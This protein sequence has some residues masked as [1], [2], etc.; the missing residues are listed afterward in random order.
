MN[1]PTQSATGN[2]YAAS[3]VQNLAA[4]DEEF[5]EVKILAVSGRIGR[6]RYLMYSVGLSILI[7]FVTGMMGALL[8]L[9]A[10]AFLGYAVLLV[11]SFML[12]IQRCHDFDASGWWSLAIFIP[13]ASFAFLLIPGTD[14]ENR[15][16]NKTPPN[17]T[18]LVVLTWLL[19]L[20]IPIGGILAAIAIP[21][22]QKYVERA[23]AEQTR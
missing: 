10:L 13:L 17:S 4:D 21:Q 2:P 22:Y 12:T 1:Q 14:G 9:P 18:G 11:L 23:R 7:M 19:V 3:R 6:V 5:Q 20:L 15:W 16:G 8:N